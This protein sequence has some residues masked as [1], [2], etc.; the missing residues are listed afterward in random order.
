MTSDPDPE[1]KNAAFVEYKDAGV[2]SMEFSIRGG[3][4]EESAFIPGMT[5]GILGLSALRG[6]DMVAW[7]T[8]AWFD[9]HV[10]CA[11]GSGCEENADARLLTDRWRSDERSGQIDLNDDPN[12]F[13]FYFRSRFDFLTADGSEVTC[14]D[15]RAAR[16]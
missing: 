15:M 8:T 13:S 9:K 2:D 5:T 16:A 4:H 14:D 12:A 6:G 3:S 10:K 11:P 1:A 7:Y